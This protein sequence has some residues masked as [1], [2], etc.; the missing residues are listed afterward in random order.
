M[1]LIR[2]SGTL[3]GNVENLGLEISLDIFVDDD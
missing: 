3:G 1:G 2:R